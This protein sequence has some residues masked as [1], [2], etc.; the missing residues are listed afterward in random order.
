MFLCKLIHNH[1]LTFKSVS[2]LLIVISIVFSSQSIYAETDVDPKHDYASHEYPTTGKIETA[3][4]VNYNQEKVDE[5][6]EFLKDPKNISI[7]NDKFVEINQA[8]EKVRSSIQSHVGL[9]KLQRD[10]EESFKEIEI[11]N[12]T[13]DDWEQKHIYCLPKNLNDPGRLQNVYVKLIDSKYKDVAPGISFR[14]KTKFRTFI[15]KINQSGSV[16]STLDLNWQEINKDIETEFASLRAFTSWEWHSQ[17]NFFNTRS[18]NTALGVLSKIFDFKYDKNKYFHD[19]I[20]DIDVDGRN[21][22]SVVSEKSNVYITID[23]SI[24]S[25]NEEYISNQAN[26]AFA[27]VETYK[28]FLGKVRA[29]FPVIYHDDKTHILIYGHKHLT[30]IIEIFTVDFK[31]GDLITW[32]WKI[33]KPITIYGKKNLSD[34]SEIKNFRRLENSSNKEIIGK[35]TTAPMIRG[36]DLPT[37]IYWLSTLGRFAIY[38]EMTTIGDLLNVKRK[39]DPLNNLK[40]SLYTEQAIQSIER[41][42]ISE[43]ELENAREIKFQVAIPHPLGKEEYEFFWGKNGENIGKTTKIAC[44]IIAKLTKGYTHKVKLGI[45]MCCPA[46]AMENSNSG[47]GLRHNTQYIYNILENSSFPSEIKM[48]ML[49]E[50]ELEQ[51]KISIEKNQT[52]TKSL[53]NRDVSLNVI[54]QGK[55]RNDENYH[56]ELVPQIIED[57]ANKNKKFSYSGMIA[58][59]NENSLKSL[60]FIEGQPHYSAE[61]ILKKLTSTGH[62]NSEILLGRIL[63]G[64]SFLLEGKYASDKEILSNAMTHFDMLVDMFDGMGLYGLERIKI[65]LLYH[66]R[67]LRGNKVAANKLMTDIFN[68]KNISTI[69]T[70]I[71][72]YGQN[73]PS[74]YAG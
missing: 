34:I 68:A 10:R 48:L 67:H 64:S 41:I 50:D 62:E 51:N 27:L 6:F 14:F 58:T 74:D 18:T 60:G 71:L 20:Q 31:S 22:D 5:I 33:D 2:R 17:S 46:P 30:K 3:W 35:I 19:D 29:V 56:F 53:L 63:L 59:L 15:L 47:F 45:N 25:A 8:F 39:G 69:K 21:L 9:S 43:Y 70:L 24:I 55:P 23:K 12:D 52:F 38:T 42:I 32:N 66:V 40:N 16:D 4:Q 7:H 37:R 1:P 61:Y 13:T 54:Y 65:Q 57:Y 36:S 44:A 26:T 49:S 11:K 72:S 73:L 28:P